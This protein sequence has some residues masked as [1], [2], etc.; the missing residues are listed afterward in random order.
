MHCPPANPGEGGSTPPQST[1]KSP[2]SATVSGKPRAGFVAV[3]GG[4]QVAPPSLVTRYWHVAPA[5]RGREAEAEKRM[6]EGHSSFANELVAKAGMEG[7]QAP[8][9][10]YCRA[11]WE[12]EVFTACHVTTSSSAEEDSVRWSWGSAA[13]AEAVK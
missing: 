13:K 5:G 6:V 10:E 1:P 7:D 12:R 2:H 9:V 4:D 11:G 3:Y 8:E